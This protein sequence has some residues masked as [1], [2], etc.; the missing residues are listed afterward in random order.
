MAD[1]CPV[2]T[3]LDLEVRDSLTDEAQKAAPDH[4]PGLTRLDGRSCDNL[5]DEALK[6][7]TILSPGL[8]SRAGARGHVEPVPCGRPGR[9][10]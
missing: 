9:R 7:A 2:L 8:T 4:C 5:A 6:A 10:W 1:H 3:S